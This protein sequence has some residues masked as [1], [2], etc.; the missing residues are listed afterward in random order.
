MIM[1]G[2]FEHDAFYDAC[3]R[4]GILIWHD[5]MTACGIYPI[6]PFLLKSYEE[7]VRAQ[8]KRL[9][10][11][12]SIAIWCGNN[13]DFMIADRTGV[14][15]DIGDMEGPWDDTEMPHR[16]IYME[17]YPKVVK[18]LTP[19]IPYWISSPFGGPKAN[20]A[21]IGDVHQ[22]NGGIAP[23]SSDSESS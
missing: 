13:E 14:K 18:E 21:T 5:F 12:P 16:K 4:A 23:C 6:V 11:H 19:E 20:D 2:I 3:D 8:V 9:R 15:Y 1:T 22:W 17:I 7:E 10:N